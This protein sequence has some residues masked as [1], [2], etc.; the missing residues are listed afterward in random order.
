MYSH[1]INEHKGKNIFIL[2]DYLPCFNI[3]QLYYVW[4]QF[5]TVSSNLQ[6]SIVQIKIKGRQSF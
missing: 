3:C 1:P 4:G 5:L 2:Q 6:Q